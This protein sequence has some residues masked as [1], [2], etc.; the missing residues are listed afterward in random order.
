[1]AE[2]QHR[3]PIAYVVPTAWAA[4]IAI[5]LGVVAGIGVGLA[6]APG[7]PG[8]RT[9][10][11]LGLALGVP[12]AVAVI[13]S[14]RAVQ[15]GARPLLV[16]PFGLAGVVL[17]AALLFALTQLDPRMAAVGAALGVATGCISLMTGLRPARLRHD[18]EPSASPPRPR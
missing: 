17:M 14:R 11:L 15:Q 5:A 6:M 4:A 10:V 12:A 7:V 8:L 13:F 2:A 16:A 3:A 9:G 18:A 1:M